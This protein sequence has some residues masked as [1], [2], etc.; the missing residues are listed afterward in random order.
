MLVSDLLQ[1]R[2]G[3]VEVVFGCETKE[4]GEIFNQEADGILGLGNSE[5]SLVNQ[6]RRPPRPPPGASDPMSPVVTGALCRYPAPRCITRVESTARAWLQTATGRHLCSGRFSSPGR[7]LQTGHWGAAASPGGVP[8]GSVCVRVSVRECMRSLQELSALSGA[9]LLVCPRAQLAGR[10]VIDDVFALCFG[11]V[12]GDGAL[13]LGDVEAVGPGGDAPVDLEFTAL[14]SSLAHPH[15]YSVRLES[16]WVGD[17]Q[18]P[19]RPVRAPP[20]RC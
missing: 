14:L 1:L 13:M 7:G 11:S 19:V 16:L 20:D 17:E 5:V 4:T 2:D 12:E 18:L 9:P 8:L 10:G 15:Y 6:V 3:G